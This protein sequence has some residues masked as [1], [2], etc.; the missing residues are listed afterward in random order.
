V[1]HR[2]TQPGQTDASDTDV[3]TALTEI[4]RLS[5]SKAEAARARVRV[6]DAVTCM[7]LGS[8]ERS[9]YAAMQIAREWSAAR[10]RC[11]V[12]GRRE[13]LAAPWAAFVNATAAHC[14]EFDDA[15]ADSSVQPGA[16]IVPTVLALAEAQEAPRPPFLEAVVAGY[17]VA[18]TLGSWLAPSHKRLGFHPSSTLTTVGA[19]AAACRLLRLSRGQTTEALRIS[20]SF[21]SG[22]LEFT[23]SPCNVNHMH[24]ARAAL[25][26]ILSAELARQGVT[27]PR[28]A[29]EG[30]WGLRAAM[31][32]AT[33]APLPARST[34]RTRFFVDVVSKP[35]PSCRIT[36]SAID[37]A[38]SLQPRL[39]RR[40]V[41]SVIDVTVSRQC[42]DQ[43]DNPSAVTLKERQF[44]V[45]FCV[46]VALARGHP[47]L[48]LFRSRSDARTSEY[49]S[50]VRL[51]VSPDPG[52]PE[53][54]AQVAVTY[55]DGE[56]LAETVNVPSGEPPD[57]ADWQ[58]DCRILARRL[59]YADQYSF[60]ETIVP[61][62]AVPTAMAL[63]K[64]GDWLSNVR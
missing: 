30:L 38:V 62:L 54:A 29:F 4:S 33:P 40:E 12:V 32:D 47:T 43:T 24:P 41:P 9:T 51:H 56:V 39:R 2:T 42:H 53:R 60:L 36:H 27:G 55:A 5:L 23:R 31:S 37:A 49:V 25:T 50:L 18:L 26:G 21:A 10:G 19:A 46:A 52:W 11:S 15:H 8:S 63:A 35:Y 59:P 6:A 16:A 1:P 20:T 3:A 57:L 13:N 64:L 22:L 58:A 28:N 48:Q 17:E 34:N 14:L 7:V 44:S 61:S 45:Q